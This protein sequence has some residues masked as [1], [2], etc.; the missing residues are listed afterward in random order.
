M[1]INEEPAKLGKGARGHRRVVD[2]RARAAGSGNL[3][4]KDQH[5]IGDFH[6]AVLTR[7]E[8]LGAAGRVE[9]PFY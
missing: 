6:S 9:N 3:T 1:H 5:A 7:R 4:T 2:P 8:H